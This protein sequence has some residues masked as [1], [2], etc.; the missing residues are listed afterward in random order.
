MG[1][2]TWSLGV[3]HCLSGPE[4]AEPREVTGVIL[5][6]SLALVVLLALRRV[7]D[8]RRCCCGCCSAW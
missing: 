6:P 3:I 1:I 7:V 5:A 8:I 2:S 4:E